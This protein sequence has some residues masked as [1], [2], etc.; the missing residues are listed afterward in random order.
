MKFVFIDTETTGLDVTPNNHE[1]IEF[2]FIIED[3]TGRIIDRGTYK[4][5]PARDL[6]I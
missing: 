3:E 1:V 5:L 2:C 6:A 4:V